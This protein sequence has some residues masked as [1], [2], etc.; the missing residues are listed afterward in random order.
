MR[1]IVELA[2]F[3]LASGQNVHKLSTC[4]A[5]TCFSYRGRRYYQPT[6]ILVS[7]FHFIAE[8]TMSLF[9]FDDAQSKSIGQTVSR[10]K[11]QA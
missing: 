5:I 4:L 7:E 10:S 8:T 6:A 9:R 2:R 3:E 1:L 11:G